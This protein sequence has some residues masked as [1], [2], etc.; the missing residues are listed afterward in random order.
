MT[1]V[2][3]QREAADPQTSPARLQE[4]AQAHRDAWPLIAANPQAYDGLLDWLAEHGD[5]TVRE[6]IA[7]RAAA[8]P[9]PPP[10][11]GP[12]APP[13]PPE[14]TVAA[15]PEPTVAPEPVAPAAAPEPVAQVAAP[16]PVAP[17]AA[18]EPVA[19]VA[20]TATPTPA[21]TAQQPAV[22]AADGAET[23]SG[24][25]NLVR[26]LLVLGVVAALVVGGYF[27]I[28]AINGD[29]DGGSPIAA[30]SSSSTSDGDK[31]GDKG[32][33]AGDFCSAMK[34][35]RDT[36]LGNL[37]DMDSGTN[38]TADLDDL[39][40]KLDETT[41][42]YQELSKVAPDEIADEVKVL[43]DFMSSSSSIGG[44]SG[45]SSF[46]QSSKDYLDASTKVGQYY[47]EHCLS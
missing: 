37:E 2:D 44:A 38:S 43:A 41:E 7:S 35:V 18:P 42:K 13:A 21:P 40:K 34:E 1:N 22:P 31:G 24:G 29:D 3:P 6:A 47:Y 36:S 28:K 30:G 45:S 32:G 16:E 14:P 25:T 46:S 10:P 26:T 15:A 33:D 12:P 27:G 4:I 11:P 8:V 39:R 19:T 20:S 17:S 9:P 5:D 23:S